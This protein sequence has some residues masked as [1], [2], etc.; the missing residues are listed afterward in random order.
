MLASQL[1][2][3]IH[4]ILEYAGI[5][6]EEE[7]TFDDLVTSN[8]RHLRF[9][10]AIF[11][12]DGNLDCLIEAQGK[13]HYVAVPKFGGSKGLYRQKYNDDLKK[14]YCLKNNIRL[15]AIPYFDENKINY[16]Y[17]IRLI[18]GY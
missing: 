16:D 6:F 18:N 14:R 13:Q 8:G 7:Y 2:I 1:E 4:D 17:I 12:D 15:I 9:D 11:D 5:T 3:K 10:F